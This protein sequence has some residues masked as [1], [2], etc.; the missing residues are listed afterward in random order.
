M[1]V[2]EARFPKARAVLYMLVSASLPLFCEICY[3]SRFVLFFWFVKELILRV[4]HSD[5][6]FPGSAEFIIVDARIWVLYTRV[7]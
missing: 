2:L 4:A 3:G 5:G 6:F 7:R 1:D